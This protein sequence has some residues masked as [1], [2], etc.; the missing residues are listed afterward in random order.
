MTSSTFSHPRRSAIR[1]LAGLAGATAWSVVALGTAALADSPASLIKAAKKEGR[2]VVDGPPNNAVR[3][4]L[5]KAFEKRY[6]IQVAYISSG[7]SKSGSRVRAERAGGKY[8]L[9][10]FISGADTPLLTFKKSGWLVP[11]ESALV[12]PE[13]TNGANWTDGHL[14]YMD[15]D[16]TVLRLLRSVNPE[17]V[18]NTKVVKADEIQKWTDLL[19]PKYK[20][21]LAAKDP[22]VSGAGA[23]LTAYFYFNFGPDFVRKLYQGQSPALTRSSRQIAQW[24]AQGKYPIAVGANITEFR[25]F[26][27]RGFPVTVVFPTDGPSIVS[28]GFGALCLMNKAPHPNAAKLFVNWLASKEGQTLFSKALV[29]LSLR[30]DVSNAWA[31]DYIIPKKGVKYMDTYDYDFITKHR[32]EGFKRARKLL[33]L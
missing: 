30:T 17:L 5:T 25:K 6:G 12:D 13:V 33:G 29:F 26:K 21:K 2:V 19:K 24:A 9:D 14:W 31:P 1:I 32:A 15:P 20:G 3:Q 8:L 7:T 27:K 10:V 28:G 18:V 22:S 23:S 4:V 11:I 16:K